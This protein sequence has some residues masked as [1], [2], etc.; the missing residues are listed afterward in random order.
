MFLKLDH[1]L[2]LDKLH[3]HTGFY[4]YIKS[5]FQF[6]DEVARRLMV[7][8]PKSIIIFVYTTKNNN[9]NIS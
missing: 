6:G 3:V 5:S 2:F 9:G 8:C 7:C 4:T 1:I